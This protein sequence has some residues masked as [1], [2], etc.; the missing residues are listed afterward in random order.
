MPRAGAKTIS[1]D[2]P[3]WVGA[4]ND[5]DAGTRK[6]PGGGLEQPRPRGRP[7]SAKADASIFRATLG[8]LQEQG[9][10]AFSMEAVATRARVGKATLYRRFPSKRELITAALRTMRS[11]QPVPDTGSFRGDLR[12]V[13]RREV[14]HAK[15][16]PH[17][18]RLAARLLGD[19]ADE[20]RMLALLRETVIAL[21][22]AMLGEIVCRGI[23]RGE[24]RSDLD[25]PL[26]S[27]LLHA[28]L[29]L[30]FLT[31]GGRRDP[32]GERNSARLVDMAL[33][34][35]GLKPPRHDRRGKGTDG[36]RRLSG[37]RL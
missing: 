23:A 34:G 4:G 7:R 5:R 13:V 29:V 12:E 36:Q 17:I 24:L 21:D 15:R 10:R 14:A 2:I 9:F 25:V 30:R 26:A 35:L 19:V 18:G 1:S 31:S 22:Y 27:E 28:T 33:E 8:I 16:V 32:L 20:P 11:S 3:R 6:P 37:G